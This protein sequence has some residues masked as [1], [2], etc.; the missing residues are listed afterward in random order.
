LGK[1]NL[2]LSTKDIAKEQ[3]NYTTQMASTVSAIYLRL[4]E[5]TR[6]SDLGGKATS[7]LKTASEYMDSNF[8]PTKMSTKDL[9]NKVYNEST[10]FLKG[11]ASEQYEAAKKMLPDVS[12]FM[13]SGYESIKKAAKQ[14]DIPE[15]FEDLKKRAEPIIEKG[16]EVLRDLNL[17]VKVDIN[18]NSTLLAN[19]IVDEITKN[20]QTKANFV[21]I[22][23]KDNRAYS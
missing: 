9:L 7:A 5:D 17:M 14:A 3:L 8:D 6:R 4:M 11:Q 13:E 21:S 15:S 1:A 12:N 22:L 2:K 23:T 19:M 10:D 16:K 18:S 20:P